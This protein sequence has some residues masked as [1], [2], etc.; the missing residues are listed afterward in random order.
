MSE[1]RAAGLPAEEAEDRRA[2]TAAA[3]PL[4]VTPTLSHLAGDGRAVVARLAAEGP[5]RNLV[6]PLGHIGGLLIPP[7][8]RTEAAGISEHVHHV[9]AVVLGTIAGVCAVGGPDPLP[10]E[11]RR[12]QRVRM[13][14]AAW[15]APASDARPRSD[16][17]LCGQRD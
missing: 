9:S 8:S 10:Q 6:V 4:A 11:R 13:P 16:V 1:G 2:S 7:Q 3:G 5:P 12:T 17:R 14:H 15:S